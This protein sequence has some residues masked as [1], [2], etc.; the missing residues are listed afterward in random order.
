M[1]F[2]ISLLSRNKKGRLVLEAGSKKNLEIIDQFFRATLYGQKYAS[3][4]S[5]IGF[6][7]SN[8]IIYH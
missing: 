4:D 5:D 8:Q 6:N 7:L 2:D 3:D 1:K